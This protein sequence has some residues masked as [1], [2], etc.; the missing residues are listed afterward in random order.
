M[1]SDRRK[2]RKKMPVKNGQNITDKLRICKN[3]FTNENYMV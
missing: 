1:R 3:Y 2:K